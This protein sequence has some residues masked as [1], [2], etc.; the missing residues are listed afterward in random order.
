MVT[1]VA[2]LDRFELCGVGI[3]DEVERLAFLGRSDSG[4]FDWARKGLTFDVEDRHLDGFVVAL[5]AGALLGS[6]RESDVR[7]FTGRV[8]MGGR[9]WRPD[10][11]DAERRFTDAWG[12]PFWRD[13]DA[14]EILLFFEFP[15]GEVQVELS[16]TGVPQ[17]VIASPHPLLADPEQRASYGV[18]KPWP[19]TS[20]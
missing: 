7:Q 18:T 3:G 16:L 20:C 4:A 2:D 13:E 11:L 14:D 1:L 12:E 19:T 8:R 17:I 6:A 10:E 9:D 5:R 15:Q